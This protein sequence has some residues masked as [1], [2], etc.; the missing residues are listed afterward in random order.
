MYF[1]VNFFSI[2]LILILIKNVVNDDDDEC[3]IPDL[4]PDV[5]DNYDNDGKQHVN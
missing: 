2:F 4:D 1:A 3:S 5:T